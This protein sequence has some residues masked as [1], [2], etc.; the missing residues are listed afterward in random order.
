MFFL[1]IL[2]SS[3]LVILNHSGPYF[4]CSLQN[5]KM[6]LR[7]RSR[8][9]HRKHIQKKLL[10]ANLNYSLI[11]IRYWETFLSAFGQETAG[12]KIY[13]ILVI[14]DAFSPFYLCD[15]TK[16]IRISENSSMDTT[17]EFT[18]PKCIYPRNVS[19]FYDES[20][21]YDIRQLLLFLLFIYP[22]L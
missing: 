22:L 20:L 2:S 18:V 16:R 10:S 9:Q 8:K 3:L 13:S 15:V 11:A 1:L 14:L 7:Q 17:N 6:S 21:H 19:C 12:V 4:V 5:Y